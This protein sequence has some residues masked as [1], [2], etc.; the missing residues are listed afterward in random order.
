[1]TRY[2]IAPN[3][4][5]DC[6]PALEVG[7]AIQKGILSNNP[8]SFTKVIPMADGGQGTVDAILYSLGGTKHQVQVK[9]PLM[10]DIQTF[11]GILADAKTA[12]IEMAA[13]SGLERL[14][15]E[16]R[17]P[18]NTSS[19]GTGQLIAHTLDLGCTHIIIG[20]GGS[21]TNDGGT[22]MAQALG[23]QFLNAGGQ[24]I[25][26]CGGNLHKIAK[27]DVSMMDRRLKQASIQVITDVVNPFYGP[28]GASFVFGP[29]KGAA[30]EMVLELEK[31]MGHYAT[32]LEHTFGIQI[33]SIVGG[34]AAGGVGA[35]LKIFAGAG[36]VS[37]TDFL[38]GLFNLDD[39]I[40]NSDVVITAEGSFDRQTLYGKAPMGLAKLAKK[41]HKP[42]FVF[43]GRAA[44]DLGDLKEK[45]ITAVVPIGQHPATLAESIQQAPNWLKAAG[46]MT[47]AIFESNS[48]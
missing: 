33:N 4:F 36:L 3:S 9:D 5:K 27:I 24:K 7:L 48:H 13:A 26:P 32:L 21:A 10:R 37:G 23:V 18:W 39:E 31:G 8:S 45:G 25:Q 38:A 29:Q 41:Y 20:I 12:I 47:A 2:L 28:T 43:T 35:A 11:F 6:L 22:G 30:Y 40:R 34:G 46:F 15:P 44:S 19:Y 16:E 14:I 1:M 17:N 42:L